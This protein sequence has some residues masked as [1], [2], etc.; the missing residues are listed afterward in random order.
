MYSA[1]VRRVLSGKG[2]GIADRVRVTRV[3]KVF[4]GLLMPRPD[5]GDPGTIIIKLDN[6]YNVGIRMSPG[7]AIEKD[8][9]R[10]PEEVLEEERYELGRT[11]KGLLSVKFDPGKPAISI[12]ATGGTIASRVD[13]RTGGV[14]A[15]SDPRELLHNVP[16]LAGIANVRKILR[17]F[18]VMSENMDHTHWAGIARA[19]AAELNAKETMGAIVTH[20]TDT[21]HFT[22][23]ALSFFLRDPGKPV[24]L[25]GAQRSSDRGS[26]DAGMNLVCSSHAALSG[27]AGVGICMHGSVSDT[28]CILCRGTKVRKMHTSRRDAFRPINEPPLAR[29]W[30]D[31]RIEVTNPVFRKRSPGRIVPDVRFEPRVAMLQTYPGSEPEVMDHLIRKGCRGFVIQA[32]GLGQVPIG[33]KSWLP[34]IKRAVASGVPVFL[35]AETVYGRLNCNVYSEGRTV[36]NAGAVPLEDMLAETAYVKL[37]WVLGHTRSPEKAREMMLTSHAGEISERSVDCFLC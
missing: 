15:V 24:V 34:Q 23:A 9:R 7:V 35:A 36:L 17:P 29:I 1:S 12:I 13:Y 5:A 32:T 3:G 20:G 11:A 21:L 33:K 18:T 8:S 30:P 10:P 37:G 16:E 28:C 19:C 6:G 2:I 4:V 27:I 25:T 31:G 14:T 26:S 22:S